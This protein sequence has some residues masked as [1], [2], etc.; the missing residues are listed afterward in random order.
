MP[1]AKKGQQKVPILKKT[2]GH[3]PSKSYYSIVCLYT[4]SQYSST[5]SNKAKRTTVD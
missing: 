2:T 4:L 3:C 1:R 5:K